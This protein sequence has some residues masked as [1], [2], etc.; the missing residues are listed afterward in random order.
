MPELMPSADQGTGDLVVF[1]LAKG[2]GDRTIREHLNIFQ[3]EGMRGSRAS[4]A[5]FSLFGP[6]SATED[7]MHLLRAG[8]KKPETMSDQLSWAYANPKA[9]TP[10]QTSALTSLQYF[11]LD[12]LA[13]IPQTHKIH[14]ETHE[15]TKKATD[16][17]QNVF[18]A[19]G[20]YLQKELDPDD[21]TSAKILDISGL[22]AKVAVRVSPLIILAACG[23]KVT[24]ATIEIPVSEPIQAANVAILS[25]SNN[26]SA[27]PKEIYRSIEDSKRLGEIPL[28]YVLP[29][30]ELSQ[31]SVEEDLQMPH[32]V[33]PYVKGGKLFEEVAKTQ[34]ILNDKGT[35]FIITQ[36]VSRGETGYWYADGDCR[37][38]GNVAGYYFIPAPEGTMIFVP[39]P[40]GMTIDGK[41][42]DLLPAPPNT[43]LYYETGNP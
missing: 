20:A 23:L 39:Y 3:K 8:D 31:D 32:A 25:K 19:Y 21:P 1:T 16:T 24:P 36:L 34:W 13:N 15:L 4:E 37:M 33:G 22:T 35:G 30:P 38:C 12:S 5:L 17:A 26:E 28:R 43:Q 6:L 40:P 41:T 29:Q 27:Q 9:L 2:L 11:A 14:G 10:D 7:D 42:G 18:E